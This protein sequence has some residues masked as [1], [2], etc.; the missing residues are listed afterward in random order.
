[1]N[2][3]VNAALAGFV[4]TLSEEIVFAQVLVRRAGRGF[5]LRHA[6]DRAAT[7]AALRAVPLDELR[8]LA[9]CDAGGE[10]RPLKA[11]PD[12]VT[13]WRATAGD[14]RELGVALEQ[15]Y[16]GALVDWF[17][18]SGSKPPV[19]DYREFTARQTGMYRVTALLDDVQAARVVRACCD[20]RLCL[21]RRL[22]SLEGLAADAAEGKSVIPC[23]EPCAVLLELARKSARIEQEEKA[24]VELSASEIETVREA[25]TAA[26]DGTT[27]SVRCA[28]FNAPLNRRRVLLLAE[29]LASLTVAR[30]TE[31]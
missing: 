15:L 9:Q 28:D 7:D 19:T 16:P 30:S 11:S 4:A 1:M 14:E 29:K 24:P 13:G 20:A 5:A 31:G 22:W 27:A 21:K 17:A 3:S 23:L 10:F 18:A 2:S 8:A 6:A 25:L 12:L 26:G